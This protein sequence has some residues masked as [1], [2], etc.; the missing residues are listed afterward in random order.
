MLTN[1]FQE[2]P[3]T[4]AEPRA[5]QDETAGV[6][7]TPPASFWAIVEVMGHS[8]FAGLLTEATLGGSGFIRLDVPEIPELAMRDYVQPARAAFTK[9]FRP[10]A[11][12]AITPC[13]EEL[14]RQFDIRDRPAAILG[15]PAPIR[16]QSSN[17]GDN[18]FDDEEPEDDAF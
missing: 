4:E 9:Y 14:A 8:R 13:N 3:M 1:N 6:N 17:V 10:A 11:I 16:Q 5:Q 2:T 15:L 7:E 12:F 18:P